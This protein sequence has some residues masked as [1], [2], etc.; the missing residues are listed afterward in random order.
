MNDRIENFTADAAFHGLA[1]D[2]VREIAPESEADPF[3]LLADYL[4]AFGNAVGRRPHIRVGPAKHHARLYVVLVGA[5][6]KARKGTARSAIRPIFEIADKEWSTTRVVGGL[7]SGEGLINAVRDPR[8]DDDGV[9]DKRL[10][11]VEEEFSSVLKVAAREGNTLSEVVRRAWDDGTLSTLTRADPLRATNTHVSVL[12]H[13]TSSELTKRLSAVEVGN[14]FANRFM[15]QYVQRAQLL[16][17]GGDFDPELLQSQGKRTLRALTE[18]SKRDGVVRDLEADELWARIYH[19]VESRSDDHL[20]G[21]LTARASAHMT[22]LQLVYALLDGSPAITTDHVAAAYDFWRRADQTVRTVFVAS[23]GDRDAD[24]FLDALRAAGS[25]GLTR[26]DVTVDV[27]QRNIDAKKLDGLIEHLNGSGRIV[28]VKQP[29]GS[30]RPPVRY[31]LNEQY[32]SN[33]QNLPSFSS[34]LS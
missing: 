30:G 18:A 15:F 3:A 28:E 10:L 22:R 9:N 13:I 32:E 34:F 26:T 8:K 21:A 16:P 11:V 7:S 23:T 27:F 5:T 33:E 6:S 31:Y 24:R 19:T 12:A 20:V 25:D 1:G 4:V 17:N 29:T 2:I 14:G